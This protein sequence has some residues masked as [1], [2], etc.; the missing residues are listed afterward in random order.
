MSHELHILTNAN[1]IKKKTYVTLTTKKQMYKHLL[2]VFS[3]I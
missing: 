3:H 1:Q 2:L